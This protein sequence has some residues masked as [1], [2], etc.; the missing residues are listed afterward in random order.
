MKR[1]LLF[2][3]LAFFCFAGYWAVRPA[4]AAARSQCVQ[5]CISAYLCGPAFN[6]VCTG[7][8]PFQPCA[9]DTCIPT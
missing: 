1:I 8:L 6:R 2:S 4:P 3:A 5:K 7:A 9:D